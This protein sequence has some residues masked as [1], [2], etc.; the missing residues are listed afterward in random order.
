LNGDRKRRIFISTE[1]VAMTHAG[2][3]YSIITGD[4]TV[5]A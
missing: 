5:I 2:K 1:V 3:K 4:S